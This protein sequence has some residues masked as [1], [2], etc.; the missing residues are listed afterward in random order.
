MSSTWQTQVD[1]VLSNI[2][3]L[4]PSLR[5]KNTKSLEALL[6]SQKS[7]SLASGL[8]DA[9]DL[10]RQI[11]FDGV[12]KFSVRQRLQKLSEDI[13]KYD[14]SLLCLVVV[15]LA[16]QPNQKKSCN[17]AAASAIAT[18]IDSYQRNL[19]TPDDS[20]VADEL[21]TALMKLVISSD[22]VYDARKIDLHIVA[23]LARSMS[24][25]AFNKPEMERTTAT[26]L[27]DVLNLSD[28]EDDLSISSCDEPNKVE[29][30]AALTLAAQ[31]APWNAVSPVDM[32]NCAILQDLWHA[33]ERVCDSVVKSEASQIAVATT[34]ALIDAAIDA[35][36]YRRAD[37][38]A[39]QY[40]DLGGASR[41]LEARFLHACD[42]IAKVIRKG[43]YAIIEKQVERVD[44]SVSRVLNDPMCFSDKYS[45]AS[46]SL[47]TASTDIRIFALEQLQETGITD[48]AHRLAT[49][50]KMEYMC[51]ADALEAAITARKAKYLQWET[52]FPDCNVPDLLSTPKSLLD[53]FESFAKNQCLFG[54]DVE[55]GEDSGAD[56]LQVSTLTAILLIDIP[57]LSETIEGSDAL[58]K[59]VGSLF[60]S[61]DA[62]VV[63][64]CCRQDIAKLRATSCAREKHWLVDSCAIID[65]QPL[66]TR[67]AENLGQGVGLSRCSEH[68]LGKP[69]D[70]S[71]QCSLWS[72]R[73]LTV[74]Q[75][76][77]AALDA[78]A[79]AAI[80]EKMLSIDLSTK[81]PLSSPSK[82]LR[83]DKT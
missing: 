68:Y 82:K 14:L 5:E 3:S 46:T 53:A 78:Y 25:A 30:A 77:Y 79:C 57:K 7:I 15:A 44:Q 4:T 32:I 33:A 49:I 38:Y 81:H 61:I 45:E 73:P 76:T 20:T 43:V 41:F 9:S 22:K 34:R 52:V 67:L 37:S 74:Q 28:G 40:Y 64:F 48:T 12:N 26:L 65:L 62:T 36:M 47:E 10:F 23:A 69:L 60:S 50:W 70:K 18:T 19:E 42:T 66:A 56:L 71:E 27:R 8:V 83:E 80:Y 54:F 13:L 1:A 6:H 24:V 35:K 39:T 29:C 2:P 75:R 59:S 51:D 21:I 31:L 55:W 72:K 63:G 11:S 17:R 16:V 58:E